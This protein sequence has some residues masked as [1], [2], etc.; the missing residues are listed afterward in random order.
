MKD[1]HNIAIVYLER[2]FQN[3]KDLRDY[4]PPSEVKV[5]D[6]QG[7]LLRTETPTF[8]STDIINHNKKIKG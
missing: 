2:H 6:L 4:A 8:Y 5:F 7:H 3:I 1:N